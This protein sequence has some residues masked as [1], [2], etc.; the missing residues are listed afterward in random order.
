MG[1]SLSAGV[2]VKVYTAE[3]PKSG[4]ER[5]EESEYM[6]GVREGGG[7]KENPV[8]RIRAVGAVKGRRGGGGRGRPPPGR[9][10]CGSRRQ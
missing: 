4:G 8:I 7:Q 6:G 9:E 3:D 5:E 1:K 10:S 2:E